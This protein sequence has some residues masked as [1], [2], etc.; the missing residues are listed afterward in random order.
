MKAIAKSTMFVGSLKNGM[1]Q[2]NMNEEVFVSKETKNSYYITKDGM[3]KMFP[4]KQ[5]YEN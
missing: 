5:F 2:I 3:T 4:K 1:M